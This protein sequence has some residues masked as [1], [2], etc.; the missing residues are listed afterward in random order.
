[1]PLQITT[2]MESKPVEVLA[3][4]SEPPR[5]EALA[6]WLIAPK[7]CAYFLASKA[8]W[9]CSIRTSPGAN[10]TRSQARRLIAHKVRIASVPTGN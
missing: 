1:M 4:V 8:Y 9:G 3:P 7:W 2:A 6:R 5:G 10:S